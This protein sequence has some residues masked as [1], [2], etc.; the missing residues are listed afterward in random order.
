MLN[1]FHISLIALFDEQSKSQQSKQLCYHELFYQKQVF[2]YLLNENKI[3]GG[4][5]GFYC[6]LNTHIELLSNLKIISVENSTEPEAEFIHHDPRNK[7]FYYP[8]KLATATIVLGENFERLSAGLHRRIKDKHIHERMLNDRSD[9]SLST[10][11]FK[12]KYT[13]YFND[14]FVKQKRFLNKKLSF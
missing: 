14:V 5:C 8:N 11:D 12:E 3:V 7:E 10:A 1:A 9:S 13:R 2:P 4:L 6:T